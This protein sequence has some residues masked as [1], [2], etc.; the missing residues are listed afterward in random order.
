MAHPSEAGG[1][2]PAWRALADEVTGPAEGWRSILLTERPGLALLAG[3]RF[4]SREEALLAGFQ[5]ATVSAGELPEGRGFSVDVVTGIAGAADVSWFAL[6]RAPS[7]SLELFGAMAEDVTRLV[8]R[9]KER[10]TSQLAQL[11]LGR[12]R[13]WQAFMSR[14][15]DDRLG[16]EQELGLTGEL[17]M[18]EALLEEGMS[19][20]DGIHGWHGPL[21]GLHDFELGSGAVEVKTTL[22]GSAFPARISSL[23]QLDDALIAPLFLAAVRATLSAQGATL[24]ER[25]SRLRDRLSGDAAATFERRLL[26]AGYL[27]GHA[28]DYGRR[29]E[30]APPRILVVDDAVPR[31]RRSDVPAAIRSA[32]YELDLDAITT[33]PITMSD[34]LTRLGVAGQ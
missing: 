5:G 20:S 11:F 33:G 23:E 27:D 29:L 26:Q 9:T 22:S 2:G 12:I 17:A 31:L 6:T 32:E 16:P 1:L 13:A 7:A 10:R 30:T 3:V 24:P 8:L 15:G 14:T 21:Q 18:L 25:V 19:G 4:P 34:M 28:A